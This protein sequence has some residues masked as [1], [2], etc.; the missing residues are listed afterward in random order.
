MNK[1]WNSYPSLNQTKDI[2]WREVMNILQHTRYFEQ[3]KK[4]I[5]IIDGGKRE[6]Q[7]YMFNLICF[8]T[9]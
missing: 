1:K 7:A 5:G 2:N 4:W 3:I 9:K 8:D 6:R